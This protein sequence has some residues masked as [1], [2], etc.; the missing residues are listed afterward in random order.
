MR[1]KFTHILSVILLIFA[2]VGQSASYAVVMDKTACSMM[3]NMSSGSM[4]MSMSGNSDS[5]HQAMNQFV[6]DDD[7]CVKG[8]TCPMSGCGVSGIMTNH[9][10]SKHSHR[11]F[12]VGMSLT[13]DV[14]RNY[15]G[16]PYRPPIA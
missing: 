5:E 7:C 8:C 11:A 6:M 10:L 13:S 9:Y 15:P 3:E 4:A 1:T 2:L 12:D 16:S 14:P